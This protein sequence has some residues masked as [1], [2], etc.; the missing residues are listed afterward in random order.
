MLHSI[1]SLA[2]PVIYVKL[3]E[4]AFSRLPITEPG[5]CNGVP[6]I[7]PSSVIF[8]P[9]QGVQA[10]TPT[11]RSVRQA[12]RKK[13]KHSFIPKIT[14]KPIIPPKPEGKLILVTVVHMNVLSDL[15]RHHEV[16]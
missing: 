9:S 15:N 16:K 2:F 6:A 14:I 12:Q 13:R 4:E 5:D 1:L 3:P 7:A 10:D 11:R 8:K